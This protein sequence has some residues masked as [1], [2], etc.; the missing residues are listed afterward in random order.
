MTLRTARSP[1]E[2]LMGEGIDLG[3]SPKIELD[4]RRK[5]LEAGARG[6]RRAL[7]VSA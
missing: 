7:R 4:P 6:A 1:F 5:E 3:P 2:P